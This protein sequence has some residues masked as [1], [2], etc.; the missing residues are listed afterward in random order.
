MIIE[1]LKNSDLYELR[2]NLLHRKINNLLGL[3]NA[4]Q[5]MNSDGEINVYLFTNYVEKVSILCLNYNFEFHLEVVWVESWQTYTISAIE[6]N[7]FEWFGIQ[8]FLLWAEKF[9]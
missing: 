1:F 4:E 2:N 3:L 7:N 6:H 9:G 8:L 5:K